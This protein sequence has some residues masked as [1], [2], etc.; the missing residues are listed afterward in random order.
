MFSVPL[1]FPV[2][3]FFL[4]VS[5]IAFKRLTCYIPFSTFSASFIRTTMKK[6]NYS[7][8]AD[9][10]QLQPPAI[11]SSATSVLR[12]DGI[13]HIDEICKHELKMSNLV[14]SW[15]SQEPVPYKLP[16]IHPSPFLKLVRETT[17]MKHEARNYERHYEPRN[18]QLPSINIPRLRNLEDKYERFFLILKCC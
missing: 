12:T 16:A 11:K 15:K 2:N 7:K 1:F 13:K 8:L 5:S 6:R 9:V 10:K 14:R 3:V 18:V 4:E 17:Q